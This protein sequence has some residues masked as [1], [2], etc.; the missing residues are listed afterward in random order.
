MSIKVPKPKWRAKTLS[1]WVEHSDNKDNDAYTFVFKDQIGKSL[2]KP[3]GLV[4]PPTPSN[5]RQFSEQQDSS[6]LTR[7]LNL[8]PG[9]PDR[10][11]RRMTEFVNEFWD[12]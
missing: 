1:H 4:I 7:N 12:V 8:D 5:L 2:R 6:E 3:K 9:T 10:L 11:K